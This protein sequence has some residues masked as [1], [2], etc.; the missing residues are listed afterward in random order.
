[1]NDQ[2]NRRVP[3]DRIE[4]ILIDASNE[5]RVSGKTGGQHWLARFV[6]HDETHG[7]ALIRHFLKL[8]E[9]FETVLVS[10]TITGT[11]FSLILRLQA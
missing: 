6:D 8:A 9:P 10:G 5:T 1:M 4:A 11:L 7:P 2:A 3:A